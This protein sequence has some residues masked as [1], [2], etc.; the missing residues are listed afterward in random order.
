MAKTIDNER[1]GKSSDDACK[2][3]FGFNAFSNIQKLC[4]QIE[5]KAF[6][7]V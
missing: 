3:I 5:K 7:L 4:K 2:F 1:D 6:S